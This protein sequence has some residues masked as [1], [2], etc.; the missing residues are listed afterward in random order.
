MRRISTKYSMKEKMLNAIIIAIA[1][2]ILSL[3]IVSCD[4]DHE[5]IQQEVDY[6]DPFIGTGGHGHTFPGATLPSGM[7]QLSPD[8][9]TSGWDWCSGYH[10]SDSTIMGFSHLHLSGT[11]ASDLG[12]ILFMPCVGK[13]KWDAGAKDKPDEGYRSRFTHESEIATPGYYKVHLDDYNVTAELTTTQHVGI[14]KY[15]Y[16]K[17]VDSRMII[18]LQHGI[19]DGVVDGYIKKLNDH[20]IVGLRRSNGWANNQQVYFY[21]QF[22]KEIKNFQMYADGNIIENDSQANGHC[23]KAILDFDTEET[24][25]LFVKVGLSSVDEQSAL[26]NLIGE[27]KHWDFDKYKSQARK[28]WNDELSKIA[29][30]GSEEQKTIFYTALYHANIAPNLLSDVDGKYRGMDDK[31]HDAKGFKRYHVFSLWDTFR[32]NHPLYTITNPNLVND[33]V[34]TFMTMKDQW[35]HLPVWELWGRENYCMI[36][37]NSIPVI[38]DAWNKGL[39]KDIN[40]DDLLEAMLISAMADDRGKNFYRK[41][42]YIPA[43]LENESVSKALEYCYADW[44]IAQM[45]RE[46]GDE[47][48]YKTFSERALFYRN[49]FDE[50]TGFMRGKLSNGEWKPGFDPLYSKHRDDEYTEGNA[51]QYSWFVP[52]DVEG[53]ISLHGGKESFAIKLD[54]LFT[55]K[56][57]VTGQH[58][59]PDIS[60][61]IGQYAHGNEPSHHIAYLFSYVDQQWKTAE[62]VDEIM[63]TLYKNTKDGLAG[64]E[65][66]GQM[67]AWYVL[68]SMGFYPVNPANGVYN[69]GRPLF[70][71]V[72]ISLAA[73]KT[74]EIIAKNN[75]EDN[76][77]IQKAFLNG[78]E[79]N[80]SF[81]THKDL[82][83]G[84]KLV[85]EMGPKPNYNWGKVNN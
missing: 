5:C 28:I 38:V 25:N 29:V 10:C 50:T 77:Y 6:V 48:V 16:P 3:L 56:T 58:S 40:D 24:E 52:H 36:G 17:N 74:F 18:D 68:S 49:H 32:A 26:R 35:G 2:V 84:G 75:S 60:G 57:E 1:T 9:G 59:S 73:N 55:M 53:L 69:I 85:F 43:D 30:E 61:L 27:A 39:I 54:S 45:A 19:H 66:C 34:H 51:W 22:S 4:N 70:N 72:K 42:K 65:D 63:R 14:H 67:S 41:Y 15:A 13:V 20:T 12:D 11:G 47:E 46:I 83:K 23:V 82:I 62:Y 81:I 8:C 79:V 78:V 80:R 71:K 64:N 7:V 76:I 21:A 33:F 37:Y 31:I 44:C